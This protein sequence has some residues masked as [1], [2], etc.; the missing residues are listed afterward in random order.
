VPYVCLDSLPEFVAGSGRRVCC[1]LEGRMAIVGPV[2]PS[3]TL[4]P[5]R[6]G[7]DPSIGASFTSVLLLRLR[8]TRTKSSRAGSIRAWTSDTFGKA[9][10]STAISQPASQP[11]RMD[12]PAASTFFVCPS[13]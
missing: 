11:R 4:S 1:G 12:S 13:G 2:M 10:G 3:R 7:I 5:A 8:W 6:T 9:V